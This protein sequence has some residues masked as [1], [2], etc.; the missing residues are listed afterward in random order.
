MEPLT[1]NS[2]RT[3]LIIEDE[4]VLLDSYESSLKTDF[5]VLKA[6]NGYKGLELL[7]KNVGKIH[8]VT[9]DLLMPGIDGL[10]V[11]KAIKKDSEKYGNMPIIVLTNMNSEKV[12]K[13]AFDLNA[14]SYL[15]KSEIDSKGLGDEI[16]KV[17]GD[18]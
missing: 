9:L 3:I 10:E 11:L 6:E 8:C 12:I 7:A 14:A 18:K 4:K 17:L 2:K 15:L 16:S 5:N 1:Q 13:E